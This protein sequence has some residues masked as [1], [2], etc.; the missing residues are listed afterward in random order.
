[1]NYFEFETLE[2]TKA[3]DKPDLIWNGCTKRRRKKKM[4]GNVLPRPS[5]FWK[6]TLALALQTGQFSG[7]S[8]AQ[9]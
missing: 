5:K 6:K 2:P 4:P 9:V 8:F 7:A 3:K 1:M